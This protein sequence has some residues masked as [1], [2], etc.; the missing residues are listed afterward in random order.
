MLPSPASS[1][2]QVLYERTN[3]INTPVQQRLNFCL[4]TPPADKRH[5]STR[6]E[7]SRKRKLSLFSDDGRH[8]TGAQ[9][10]ADSDVEME[11]ARYLLQTRRR[12]PL[13]RVT[14]SVMSIPGRKREDPS[15]RAILQSFVSSNRSDVYKCQSIDDSA[16]LTTPCA[17]RVDAKR[18]G[19]P[20]MAVGTEQGTIEILKTTRRKD[21]DPELPRTTLQAHGSSIFDVKWNSDDT[22]LATCGGDHSTRITCVARETV[23]YSLRGHTRTVKCAAWDPSNGNL[24]STGG[25]DG[26]ICLWDLRVA[27]T[28]DKEDTTILSPVISIPGAHEDSLSIGKRRSKKTPTPRSITSLLYPE[29]GTY[30]LISSCSFDGI[31]KHWDLRQPSKGRKSTKTK[32]PTNLYS[33]EIDPTTLGESSRARGIVRLELGTGP[34]FGLVFGLGVDSKVHVYDAMTLNP[35]PIIYSHQ[36]MQTNSFHAGLSLSPC[37]R[38]LATG[39]EAGPSSTQGSAFLFDVGTTTTRASRVH[40]QEGVQL[41]SQQGEVGAIDWAEDA[42]ASCADDGTVRVWRPDIDIYRECMEKPE[43]RRIS[44]ATPSERRCTYDVIR[45][46]IFRRKRIKPV[47]MA[48][49]SSFAVVGAGYVELPMIRALLRHKVSVLILSHSPRHD[50]PEG[51]STVQVNYTDIASINHALREHRVE[52]VISTLDAAESLSPQNWIAEASKGAGVKLFLPSEF[53]MPTVGATV[54]FLAIKDKSTSNTPA[55]FTSVEDVAGFTAYVLTNFH[56]VQLEYITFRIQGQS[57]SLT[58]VASL[59]GMGIE[60]VEEMPSHGFSLAQPIQ[61]YMETGGGS[62]GWNPGEGREGEEKAGSSN[63]LW[64]SHRWKSVREVLQK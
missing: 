35:L 2:Q 11:D 34:T 51:V 48:N 24:L 57:A 3:C 64:E 10:D 53:S 13:Q 17:L 6:T 39:S 47:G 43:D 26:Q 60:H 42:L 44:Y 59:L 56:P 33:S 12:N 55:S 36:N 4:P 58:E 1:P 27:G 37:G 38:W 18:G 30:G 61:E 50:L 29:V 21:W 32:P 46:E 8:N 54:N 52:V 5:D 41:T 45:S 20:T 40:L 16:Y 9:R 49:Y 25:R 22:L 62:T 31:V 28:K 19:T 14:R 15:T 7:Q 63:Q 23:V